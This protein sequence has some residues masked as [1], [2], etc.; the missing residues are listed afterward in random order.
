VSVG[1]PEG[2]AGTIRTP[3]QL[4]NTGS[5]PCRAFGYPTMAFH[6]SSGWVNVKAE[7]GG[8]GDISQPPRRIVV[9]PG[10]S[11]YF[12]SY[13][14]DVTTQSGPCRSFDR[15]RITLPDNRVPAEVAASGCLNPESL[16][17]GPLTKNPPA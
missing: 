4:K 12:V 6:T 14:G 13:W 7:H 2:A 15:V 10:A 3:W 8:Y 17:L 11:L 1:T 16:R 9:D 5:T